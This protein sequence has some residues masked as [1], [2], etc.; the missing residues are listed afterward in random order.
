MLLDLRE[1]GGQTISK[2]DA[3]LHVMEETENV[4]YGCQTIFQ[5]VDIGK[6]FKDVHFAPLNLFQTPSRNQSYGS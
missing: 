2:W 5:I 4:A 6:T 3:G 1:K